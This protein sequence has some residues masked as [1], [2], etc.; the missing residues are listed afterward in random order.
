[1]TARLIEK[2]FTI[3]Q[4]TKVLKSNFKRVWQEVRIVSAEIRDVEVPGED[5]LEGTTH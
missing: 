4:M 1:M 5:D 2:G 3:E